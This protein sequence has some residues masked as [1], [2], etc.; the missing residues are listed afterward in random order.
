MEAEATRAAPLLYQFA[1]FPS[2]AP[3]PAGRVPPPHT[4]LIKTFAAGSGT[5]RGRR[6]A[7]AAASSCVPYTMLLAAEAMRGQRSAH[8]LAT[9]PAIAEPFIS[10][11]GLTITPALS[12]K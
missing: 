12:S 4:T 10:P 11:F 6:R 3:P 7:A 1:P 9:G 5:G 2:P 8:S